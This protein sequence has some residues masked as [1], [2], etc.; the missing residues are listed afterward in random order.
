MSVTGARRFAGLP[1]VFSFIWTHAPRFVKVRL[2]W[3]L[4]LLT[5]ASA[6]SAM[7]PVALEL[8][9][10]ALNDRTKGPPLWAVLLSG[11][12]V[13]SQWLGRTIG[14]LRGLTYARAERRMSRMLANRLFGHVI[15]LPFHYHVERQTT[16]AVTQ[17]LANGR[18]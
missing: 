10:D 2:M 5:L 16:G 17:I 8:I 18:L 11:L 14:E 9:V 1:E 6:L 12:F 13:M 3:A 7:G 15:R 4:L